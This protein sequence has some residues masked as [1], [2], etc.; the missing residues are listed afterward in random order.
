MDQQEVGNSYAKITSPFLTALRDAART[1]IPAYE[2]KGVR[3]IETGQ[4]R[5]GNVLATGNFVITREGPN[6]SMWTLAMAGASFGVAARIETIPQ[7]SKSNSRFLL[8][9]PPLRRLPIQR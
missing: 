6:D 2:D 7:V 5:E 4:D 8:I 3:L 9:V 1:V